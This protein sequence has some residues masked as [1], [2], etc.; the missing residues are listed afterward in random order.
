MIDTNLARAAVRSRAEGLVVCTTGSQTLSA[1][2][3]GYARTS[4]SFVTDGFLVGM[5]VTPT[6]FTQTT[7]GLITAVSASALAVSSGRTVQAAGAGRTL[8]VGLPALR[9]YENTPLTPTVGRNYVTDEWV[10]GGASLETMPAANGFLLEDGLSV[11]K[12]YGQ[13]GVGADALDVS[14][15]TFM[16]LFTPGTTLTLSDGSKLA[17]RGDTAVKRSSI[18]PL[19][20]WAVVTVTIPWRAWTRN[21]IAA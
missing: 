3:T 14:I 5:E 13:P 4:G 1:T 6:G 16:L 17:V 20:S 11:W 10:P 2:A 19:T 7:P 8:A 12:W 15:R 9:A 21:A 18:I